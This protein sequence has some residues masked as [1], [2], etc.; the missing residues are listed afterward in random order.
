MTSESHSNVQTESSAA[1]PSAEPVQQQLDHK[2]SRQQQ[3]PSEEQQQD[4][5]AL[6]LV[7]HHPC[8]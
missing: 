1:N 3:D 6:Q 4:R 8:G 5:T 7:Q 2:G